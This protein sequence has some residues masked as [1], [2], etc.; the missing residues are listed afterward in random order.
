MKE[1]RPTHDDIALKAHTLWKDRGC[2]AG[3]DQDIWLEAER[4]AQDEFSRRAQ[5]EAAA[6]SRD[7]FHLDAG[8]SD[9]DAIKAAVQR[10]AP[11]PNRAVKSFTGSVKGGSG[12]R[13][14]G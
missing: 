6:E 2:P 10:P 5:T 9:Q 13:G 7:E 4:Q 12:Q 3:I 1:K 11:R 14:L 8:T